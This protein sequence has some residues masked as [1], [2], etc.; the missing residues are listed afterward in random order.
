[1]GGESLPLANCGAMEADDLAAADEVQVRASVVVRRGLFFQQLCS[2]SRLS[3]W[4]G[5]LLVRVV[6]DEVLQEREKE[7]QGG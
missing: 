5:R 3:R 7:D 6:Q 1:M 2:Q 4:Q